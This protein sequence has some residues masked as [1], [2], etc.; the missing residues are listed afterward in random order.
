MGVWRIGPKRAEKP[1]MN[2]SEAR[3]RRMPR[4]SHSCCSGPEIYCYVTFVHTKIIF[5]GIYAGCIVLK[6]FY[7][8]R[9]PGGDGA[10]SI[11][12]EMDHRS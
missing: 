8:L 1:E 3:R 10:R 4:G 11:Q 12:P 7:A 2:D 9:D 6:T 5:E